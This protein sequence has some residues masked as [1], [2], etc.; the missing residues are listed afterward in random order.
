MRS[1]SGAY[2]RLN[3][4]SIFQKQQKP[5]SIVGNYPRLASTELKK[6]PKLTL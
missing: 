2:D 4:F 3:Q 6:Y 1:N 5:Y